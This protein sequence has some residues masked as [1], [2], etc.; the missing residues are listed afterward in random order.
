M[1]YLLSIQLY[2][3]KN[4]VLSEDL[5]RIHIALLWNMYTADRIYFETCV[6]IAL[7]NEPF[8]VI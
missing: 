8:I 1:V 6:C 7:Y 3:W 4:T 5:R 2:V